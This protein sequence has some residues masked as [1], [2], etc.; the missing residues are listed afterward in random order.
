[1]VSGVSLVSFVCSYMGF[2][3]CWMNI[4]GKKIVFPDDHKQTAECI[5]STGSY[6][7]NSLLTPLD[8]E[9]VDLWPGRLPFLLELLIS[10]GLVYC[11]V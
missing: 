8:V 7:M 2:I 6:M 3:L 5:T 10:L 11:R 1:M 4:K 9:R